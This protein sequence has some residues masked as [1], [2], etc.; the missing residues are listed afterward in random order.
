MAGNLHGIGVSTQIVIHRSNLWY[1]PIRGITQSF[2]RVQ[3]LDSA[4]AHP[5]FLGLVKFPFFYP[6]Y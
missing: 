5:W 6:F 2:S 4:Q 3:Q 1:Q